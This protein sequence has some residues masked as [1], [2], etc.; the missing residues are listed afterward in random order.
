[1]EDLSRTSFLSSETI[2]LIQ[3]HLAYPRSADQFVASN[4]PLLDSD[5]FIACTKHE[6][7]VFDKISSAETPSRTIN[8]HRE[9]IDKELAALQTE[10]FCTA[11]AEARAHC[12]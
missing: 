4:D 7:L 5:T 10:N 2:Q 12:G 9:A 6:T 3:L 8:A 1:M 11:R